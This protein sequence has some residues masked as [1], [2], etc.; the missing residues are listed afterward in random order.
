MRYR[1]PGFGI[2]RSE[3]AA[4]PPSQKSQYL[5]DLLSKLEKVEFSVDYGAGKLR[6]LEEILNTSSEV[7]IVDS[8]EQIDRAQIIF[9]QVQSI[10]DYASSKNAIHVETTKQFLE[11][12]GEYD[13]AFLA[14]VLQI[15]PIPKIRVQ[16]LKRIFRSLK[17]GGQLIACVQYRNSDFTRMA[18][19]QNSTIFKD[20]MIIKHLRGT[21]FYGFIK[22][23]IF[24]SLIEQAGFRIEDRRLHDGSCYIWASKP[25]I[26]A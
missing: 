25:P 1:I 12:A 10:R 22:P 21:S 24:Q 14:N 20:G 6:Y 4:K 5:V 11:C 16:I 7:T 15:V 26:E 3:N 19:M 2:I 9:G 8:I 23:D 17:P 13:R 18:K